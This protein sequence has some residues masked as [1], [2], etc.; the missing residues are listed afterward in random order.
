VIFQFFVIACGASLMVINGLFRDN[1]IS[2]LLAHPVWRPL[3][4]LSYGVYLVHLFVVVWVI[5][6]WPAGHHGA[7][8]WVMSLYAFIAVVLLASV[9]A[10]ALL[11]FTIERPMLDLGAR[12]SRQYLR[13]PRI[14]T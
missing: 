1:R 14:L 11:F 8:A 6:W 2:R 7:S 10:A 3:A 12:L 13:D 4:R 5:T 9:S